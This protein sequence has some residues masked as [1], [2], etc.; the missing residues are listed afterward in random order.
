MTLRTEAGESAAA[1]M[2]L[3]CREPT[4]SPVSRYEFDDAAENLPR[5]VV[6]GGKPVGAH[7]FSDPVQDCKDI[8]K[9]GRDGKSWLYR[10]RGPA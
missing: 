9:A 2:R 8:E 5:A 10:I 3:R 1:R 7:V 4:G 6:E